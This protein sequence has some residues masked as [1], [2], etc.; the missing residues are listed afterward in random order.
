MSLGVLIGALV[1]TSG[2]LEGRYALY[3]RAGTAQGLSRDTRVMLQGLQIGRVTQVNPR[4]DQATNTLHFVAELSIRER[5]PDG[6]RLLLPAGTKAVIT[7]PAAFVVAPIIDL[8]MPSSAPDRAVLQPGDTLDSERPASVLDAL[9]S[10]ASTLSRDI[11]MT[12]QETRELVA[13]STRTV[14]E[15]GKLLATTGPRLT[16]TLTRL[17]ENLDRAERTLAAV[18][19]RV[20]PL[21]DSMVATFADTRRVLL[22]LDSLTSVA[23]GMATENRVAIN[24]AIKHLHRSA[25]ILE[26]FA[27]QLSRRPLRMLTGITPPPDS[28]DKQ[29]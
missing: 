12:L 13:L 24:E 1:L 29:R 17:S 18:E 16:E 28:G 5:F 8:L 14:D 3:M 25:I 7:Q 11:T 27:D 6:T 9:S 22:Q 20:G 10:I 19:P 4:L 2:L 23:H 15:T 21:A 26:N